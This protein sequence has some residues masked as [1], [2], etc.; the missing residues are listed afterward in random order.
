ML[1]HPISVCAG[2]F[3]LLYTADYTLGILFKVKLHNPADVQILAKDISN[4]TS[5]IY[6][7]GVIYVAEKGCL[8]YLDVG[9]VVTLNPK[10]LKK[11]RLQTELLKRQLLQPGEK[12]TVFQMRQRLS[13]WIKQNAPDM[14][15]ENGLKTLVDGISP[16]ALTAD[17]DGD[18]LYV[19]Q[20]D[21]AT[22]LKVTLTFTG[23]QL[24]GHVE[25]FIKMPRKAC[26]TGFAYSK[27]SCDLYVVNS[28]DDGGI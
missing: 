13:E 2:N 22:I 12:V 4:P 15:R 17:E 3:G 5:V 6:K 20:R 7:A 1:E 16:L 10:A 23:A 19:S 9:N 25:R 26:C 21:S 14:S 18:L 27:E 8:S 24:K 28:Q 11:P